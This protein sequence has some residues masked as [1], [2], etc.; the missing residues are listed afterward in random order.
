MKEA[1]EASHLLLDLIV[2]CCPLIS[3]FFFNHL[4]KIHVSERSLKKTKKLISRCLTF[5]LSHKL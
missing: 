4:N 2:L 3:F 1:Q 5:E